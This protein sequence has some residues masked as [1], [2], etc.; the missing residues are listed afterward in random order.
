MSELME[1]PLTYGTDKPGHHPW[2][3]LDLHGNEKPVF[4]ES[5]VYSAQLFTQRA[6]DVVKNHDQAK[7]CS[8]C[9]ATHFFPKR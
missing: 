8:C 4:N 7:V 9:V 5:G 1:D 2:C 6:I 3:G